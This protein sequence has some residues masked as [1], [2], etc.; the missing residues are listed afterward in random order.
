MRR[1]TP[2]QIQFG[3]QPQDS[4]NTQ[5]QPPF[6]FLIGGWPSFTSVHDAVD[7]SSTGTSVP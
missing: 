6:D 5:G 4:Q 7:G 2:E 3:D 1:A